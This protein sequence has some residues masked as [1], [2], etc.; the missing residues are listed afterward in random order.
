MS[1]NKRIYI[2]ILFIIFLLICIPFA[3]SRNNEPLIIGT[4]RG[5]PPYS[6]INEENNPDGF[7]VELSRALGKVLG[8]EVEIKIDSW[9]AIKEALATGEID[10]IAGMYYS[11][12][13]VHS[14]YQG[15][16]ENGRN[17]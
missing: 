9:A 3:F 6:F 7:N 12:R 13:R 16:R 1:I 15:H 5:Y 17:N 4:E 8:R 10:L 11:S 2:T 14:A